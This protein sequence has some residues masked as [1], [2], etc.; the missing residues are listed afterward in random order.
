MKTIKFL[1]IIMMIYSCNS[2]RL[3]SIVNSDETSIK[4]TKYT[5]H[6]FDSLW[7]DRSIDSSIFGLYLT[8]TPPILLALKVTKDSLSILKGESNRYSIFINDTFKI[9]CVSN[10][11]YER[12]KLKKISQEKTIYNFDSGYYNNG[13]FLFL[14]DSHYLLFCKRVDDNGNTIDLPE[15]RDGDELY[16]SYLH[17]LG[18]EKK[19][20]EHYFDLIDSNYIKLRYNLPDSLF[21]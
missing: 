13:F 18:F 14:N 8:D 17:V 21:Y 2:I 10:N 5:E 6:L 19:I 1:V 3:K 12:Y 4:I 9:S 7:Q 16:F 15:Y 20:M 11:K